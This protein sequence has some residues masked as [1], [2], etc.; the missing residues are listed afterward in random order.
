MPTGMPLRLPRPEPVP[1]L[2]EIHEAMRATRGGAV[3]VLRADRKRAEVSFAGIGNIAGGVAG[4][5][6]R[7]MGP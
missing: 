6:I 1:V 7:R 3:A 2:H 4:S 5:G